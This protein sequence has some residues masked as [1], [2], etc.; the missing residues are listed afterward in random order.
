MADRPLEGKVALVTGSS[1]GMGRATSLTLAKHGCKIICC[2]L[3]PEPNPKGYEAD[4]DKTTV[5]LIEQNGGQ[6]MFQQVDI[7]NFPQAEAA[8]EAGIAVGAPISRYIVS[9]PNS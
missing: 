3:K 7:S 8:F 6:A 2:D 4:L 1:S 5:Q 9:E